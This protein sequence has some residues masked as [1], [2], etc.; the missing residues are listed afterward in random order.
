[1]R[2][3]LLTLALLISGNVLASEHLKH[4][5]HHHNIKHNGDIKTVKKKHPFKQIGIASWYGYQHAGRPTKSGEIFDPNKLTAAH[6]SLPTGTKVRVTNLKN[7]KSVI[8]K[9]NDTGGFS[10]YHRIIDLSLRAAKRIGITG[11]GRV[12]IEAI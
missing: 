2:M 7:H 11:V 1:M 8:V 6:N 3:L 12:K 4:H 9:I 10:K 5:H